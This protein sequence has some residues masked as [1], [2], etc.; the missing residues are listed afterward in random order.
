MKIERIL[1]REIFD[2][3]GESTIEVEVKGDKETSVRSQIPSGESRGKQEARVLTYEGA[4]SALPVLRN[5]LEGEEFSSI[6]EVD[7]HL[8]EL[9]GTERKEKFGGN[10][11]LGIS[12]ACARAFAFQEKRE[13]H[14]TLREEFFSHDAQNDTPLIF[15]NLINGGA[16]ARNN[17]DIQEYLV[18]MKTEG[19]FREKVR[20]LILFYRELG[21]VLKKRKG[22]INIP[23]GDEG[24]YSC[25]FLSNL[26][27]LEI[28][29]ECIKTSRLEDIFSLGLDAAAG[30]FSHSDRY[31]FDEKLITPIE[32]KNEYLQF[33]KKVKFLCS[34]E[35]P[36]SEEDKTSWQELKKETGGALII[37]D[38]LTVTNSRFIKEEALAGRI[39]G[40]II[41]PNQIGTV[42]ETC[43]AIKT[44]KRHNLK[45]IISHRSGETE[46]TFIIH[47][48]KASGAYGIK[49]GAPVR[50][51][52]SKFNEAMRVYE[53]ISDSY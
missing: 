11:V 9:D 22:A 21:E 40:V 15:S 32:L 3:R 13:L 1:L 49:I 10:V 41:K 48:A 46:D 33:F 28:L 14:E 45:T 27:P 35:D 43:E 17:L 25:N 44:A 42:S 51:R 26:E 36:F 20:L 12:L 47:L 34:L 7:D 37:G 23:I 2:S 6:R 24:G 38:D 19:I 31:F 50:E 30:N 4:K 39:S 16:H 53:T 18:I 52:I 8:R 5:A 29:E